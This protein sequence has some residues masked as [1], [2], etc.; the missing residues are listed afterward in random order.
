MSSDFNHL[1][2]VTDDGIYQFDV[3]TG[4]T[5]EILKKKFVTMLSIDFQKKWLNTRIISLLSHLLN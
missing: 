5:T 2:F 1:F 3:E 4:T